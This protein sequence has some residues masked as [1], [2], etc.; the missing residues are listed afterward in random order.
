MGDWRLNKFFVGASAASAIKPTGGLRSI[1]SN[2][3]LLKIEP[4]DG[5]QFIIASFI[6]S[7]I[8]IQKY[9]RPGVGGRLR[10]FLAVIFFGIE[11]DT[12]QIRSK[13]KIWKFSVGLCRKGLIRTLDLCTV[14]QTGEVLQFTIF[15]KE[16]YEGRKAQ[17]I[18]SCSLL[19]S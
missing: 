17:W 16:K 5:I 12:K 6:Y 11:V 4:F 9:F 14:L 1:I 13:F 2:F 10:I 8:E 19:G 18:T 7:M 15:R 3:G